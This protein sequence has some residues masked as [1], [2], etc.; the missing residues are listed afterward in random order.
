[1]KTESDGR[2]ITSVRCL[3]PMF[4][5]SARFCVVA[6]RSQLRPQ[7]VALVFVARDIDEGT[8]RTGTILVVVCLFV[9]LFVGEFGGN[10]TGRRL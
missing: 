1:M 8:D 9:C 6:H 4:F 5:G 7:G 10:L 3:M 2:V